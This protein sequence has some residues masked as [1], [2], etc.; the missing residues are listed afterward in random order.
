MK[1]ALALI[2]TALLLAPTLA[3]CGKGEITETTVTDTSVAETVSAETNASETV[4]PDTTLASAFITE[5]GAAKAKIVLSPSASD[6]EKRA[7]EELIYHIQKVSGAVLETA[8]ETAADTLSIIIGTPD[9]LPELTELFPEDIAWLTTLEEAD[10]RH[11]ADDGFAIRTQ[12]GKV[13]IFGVTTKGALNG[14]YDFIEENLGVIWVRAYEDVGLIYDEMPTIPLSKSDYRE[15]SPFQVRGWTAGG[16]G[17]EPGDMITQTMF[18]RNKLNTA[19][20]APYTELQYTYKPYSDLGLTPFLTSENIKWWVKNSPIYDPTVTEYWNTDENGQPM[21]ADTSPQVNYLS[22]LTADTVAASVIALLDEFA[23]TVKLKYVGVC[24]ADTYN[25][26]WLYE[27]ED[28]EY[29]PGQIVT[30]AEKEYLS[31]IFFSFINKIARQVKE[32]YPDVTLLSYAYDFA[33]QAP[34]CDLEDNVVAIFCPVEE[35]MTDPITDTTNVR[36]QTI[37][38]MIEE[39]KKK[40]DQ[41]VFYNYYGCFSA[42]TRYSRPAWDRI[43]TDM[44]YY[45]ESGRMGVMS[46]GSNDG[47]DRRGNIWATNA[48]TFWLYEKLAWN[49]Y[50]DVDALIKEFC[51]KCYGDA[52]EYMQEYYALL[53]GGWHLGKESDVS[54]PTMRVEIPWSTPLETYIESFI[55]NYDLQDEYGDFPARLMTALNNAWEAANDLEKERIR[56]LKENMEYILY[57]IENMEFPY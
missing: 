25:L 38:K 31:T 28:F 55:D 29:A 24:V 18:T 6:L 23:P 37:Y 15:K 9:S 20:T 12:G 33:I 36:N 19:Y 1:R 44:Q 54:T 42:S 21:T 45:A 51:D 10:G 49:P 39:W 40:T 5:N 13:Y 22:D 17:E 43:Q 14:V 3:S 52:S 47:E 53:E 30:P 34:K 11:W 57:Y 35:D 46:E 56:R 16:V 4:S 8:A 7:A 27:R 2:L 41:V 50:E 32:K 48:L 26:K